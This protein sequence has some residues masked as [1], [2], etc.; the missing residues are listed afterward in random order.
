MSP[1]SLTKAFIEQLLRVWCHSPWEYHIPTCLS[2]VECR[3]TCDRRVQ[4]FFLPPLTWAAY[5]PTRETIVPLPSSL[6]EAVHRTAWD[7][8]QPLSKI[9]ILR[10]NPMLLRQYLQQ[11]MRESRHC[12]T[13]SVHSAACGSVLPSYQRMLYCHSLLQKQIT[14]QSVTGYYHSP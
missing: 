8:M 11:H 1:P 10:S 13:K 4:C 6:S 5:R 2:E 9:M 7:R 12:L 3:E 14:E